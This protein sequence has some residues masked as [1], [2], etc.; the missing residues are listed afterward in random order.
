MVV[1]LVAFAGFVAATLLLTGGV[2]VVIATGMGFPFAAGAFVGVGVPLTAAIVEARDGIGVPSDAR[3]VDS[4]HDLQR[5]VDRLARTA[6]VPAPRVHLRDDDTPMVYVVGARPSTSRLVVS[7]GLVAAVDDGMEA[8]LAH[9]IAHVVNRDAVVVTVA[10]LPIAAAGRLMAWAEDDDG[11]PR[12]SDDVNA[13]LVFALP[14]WVAAESVG[15][16]LFALLGRARQHAA[17]RGAVALCGSPAALAVALRDVENALDERPPSGRLQSER[18]ALSIVDRPVADPELV[19]L[20]PEGERP[21]TRV[22]ESR[23]RRA[24]LARK[25]STH[26]PVADRVARLREMERALETA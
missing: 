10:Y 3:P 25:L 1:T 21:A 5:V 8:V 24:W 20:G 12:S 23:Q 4:T 17:D 22:H 14:V 11:D 18:L 26:P 2:G 9:E 16:V 6:D 19:E 13:V 7:T 15:R